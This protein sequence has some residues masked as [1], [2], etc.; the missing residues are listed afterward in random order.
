MNGTKRALSCI[1]AT[2]SAL[3]LVGAVA[4]PAAAAGG[5]EVWVRADGVW[6]TQTFTVADYQVPSGCPGPTTHTA[7]ITAT[8]KGNS[9]GFYFQSIKVKPTTSG[10]YLSN[11]V[12]LDYYRKYMAPYSASS[13]WNYGVTKTVSNKTTGGTTSTYASW[14]GSARDRAIHTLTLFQNSY[15]TDDTLC[16]PHYQILF[17]RW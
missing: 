5:G 16:S 12:W 6:R 9:S 14:S 4:S 8:M 15:G 2:A 3:G 1:L 13:T 11:I 17:K 7:T 10:V